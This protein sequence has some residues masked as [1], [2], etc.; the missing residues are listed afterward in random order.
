MWYQGHPEYFFRHG[1]KYFFSDRPKIFSFG[2]AKNIFFLAGPKYFL[3]ARPKIFSF[4]PARPNQLAL[5][6]LNPSAARIGLGPARVSLY[7]AVSL[8]GHS[9]ARS[10]CIL[11]TCKLAVYEQYELYCSKTSSRSVQVLN[12]I[13]TT[14]CVFIF[15][16]ALECITEGA[17][18]D[19]TG[20]R[21]ISR[22]L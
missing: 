12:G 4:C 20:S 21:T 10:M 7:I 6:Y 9:N 19:K 8:N 17:F 22:C 15:S 14:Q 5:F 11:V 1:P 13:R 16:P 18:Y 2:P 3:F